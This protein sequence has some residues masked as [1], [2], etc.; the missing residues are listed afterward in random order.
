MVAMEGMGVEEMKKMVKE[1]IRSDLLEQ[2]IWYSLKYD[3][4][5]LMGLDGDMDISMIFKGNVE[6]EYIYVGRTSV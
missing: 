4:Q 6:H 5:M 3:R 2:K 1:I